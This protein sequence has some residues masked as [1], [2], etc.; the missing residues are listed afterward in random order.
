[1]FFKSIVFSIAVMKM[2]I[3]GKSNYIFRILE[4]L[5][6]STLPELFSRVCCFRN[7]INC[8]YVLLNKAAAQLVLKFG[9]RT[10]WKSGKTNI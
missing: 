3:T 2:A 1:M 10:V 8:Y 9:N 5:L 7:G 4:K 6:M